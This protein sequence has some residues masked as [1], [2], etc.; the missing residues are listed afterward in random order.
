VASTVVEHLVDA[1][2]RRLRLRIADIGKPTYDVK[3]SVRRSAA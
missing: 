3:R 2:F 1:E